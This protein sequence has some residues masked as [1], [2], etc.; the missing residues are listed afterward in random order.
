MRELLRTLSTFLYECQE[1]S[2]LSNKS[3]M[4]LSDRDIFILLASVLELPL[5]VF[6]VLLLGFATLGSL[7]GRVGY[8][9]K[10]YYYYYFLLSKHTLFTFN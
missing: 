7:G 1:R 5:D 10:Y 9:F 2:S 8:K 4:L 3:C 6:L